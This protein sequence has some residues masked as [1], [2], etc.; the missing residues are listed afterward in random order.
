VAASVVNEA[1]RSPSG[2]PLPDAQHVIYTLAIRS[3]DGKQGADAATTT[4]AAVSIIVATH[5]D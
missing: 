1:D 4:I 5:L 2:Y 3:R